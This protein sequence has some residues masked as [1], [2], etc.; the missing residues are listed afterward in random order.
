MSK[1]IILSE[2]KFKKILKELDI[3]S[4]ENPFDTQKHPE[5]YPEED[6]DES[7]VGEPT[8]ET[9][10]YPDGNIGIENPELP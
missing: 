8:D 7:I 3:T 10:Y 1:T 4:N 9:N 6:H 2:E 5:R